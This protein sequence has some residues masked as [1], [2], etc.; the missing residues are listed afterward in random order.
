M[1]EKLKTIMRINSQSNHLEGVKCAQEFVASELSAMGFSCEWIIN[2]QGSDISAP[3]LVAERK[4]TDSPFITLVFHTDT[5]FESDASELV[6]SPD[7]QQIF[8]IGIADDKASVVIA[9]EGLRK[10]LN[11]FPQTSL[12]LRVI[13]SPNEEKGSQGFTSYFK[14]FA[15]TS[16]IVLGFEPALEEGHIISGRRGNRWYDI[17]VKGKEAHAGRNHAQGLNAGLELCQKLVEISNLTDYAQE[18]TVSIGHI[19]AG[20]PH[21]NVVCGHAYAK[22]DT[23]FSD[24]KSQEKLHIKIEKILQKNILKNTTEHCLTSYILKDDCPAFAPHE[25][26]ETYLQVYLDILQKIEGQKYQAKRSGGASDC[27]YFSLENIII[28]D[29]LGAIGGHLH[30]KEEYIKTTSLQTRSEA[31]SHFLQKL[32]TKS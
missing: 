20:A 11:L 10:F 13:S 23:R 31:L 28:I 19:H 7:E 24:L 26:A 9:L 18:M 32:N 14:K 4:R 2:P 5:V 22:I 30:T 16:W 1:L 27:N 6:F 21:F 12:S 25:K 15:L 29:G 17:H 8:G 3:L